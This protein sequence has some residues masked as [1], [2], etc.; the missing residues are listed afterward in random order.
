MQALD[1]IAVHWGTHPDSPLPSALSA[2]LGQHLGGDGFGDV[3]EA[4]VTEGQQQRQSAMK[5]LRRGQP[6]EASTL[7]TPHVIEDMVQELAG[8]SRV[9]GAAAARSASPIVVDG[10]GH[11]I[12]AISAGAIYVPVVT[13]EVLTEYEHECRQRAFEQQVKEAQ[14]AREFLVSSG[15]CTRQRAEEL[16]A[17]PSGKL[18]ACVSLLAVS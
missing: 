1:L 3:F 5:F 2:K 13:P 11:V 18:Y 15:Y 12:T 14:H 6:W 16:V 9:H 4:A 7:A 10:Q 17:I 8:S